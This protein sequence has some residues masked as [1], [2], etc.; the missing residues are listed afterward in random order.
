[1]ERAFDTASADETRALGERLGRL[2][3]GGEVVTLTGDLGAGKTCLTQGLALGLGVPPDRRVGSPTF[4]LV[5]E[6]AGRVALH[7]ADLYRIERE[8]EIEEIGLGEYLASG[9]VTVVEWAE[10]FSAYLPRE[11]IEVR[12]ALVDDHARRIVLVGHGARADAVLARL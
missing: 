12:I 11:R 6:H 2:L 3:L 4:T 8:E 5:N 10:R 1:M 9:G 7:H